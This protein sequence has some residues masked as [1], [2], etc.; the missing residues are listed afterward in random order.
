MLPELP[1]TSQAS[2]TDYY[3]DDDSQF[4]EALA[5]AV[6]PGD[7]PMNVDTRELEPP[8]LTQPRRKR[9]KSPTPELDSQGAGGQSED[10]EEE[11]EEELEPPPPAQPRKR[12][13][14]P[15]VEIEDVQGHL[16][17]VG[18]AAKDSV[19]GAATFGD[20]GQY[21]NRKR[22]KLQIQ[23]A[24]LEGGLSTEGKKQIFK[25]LAIYVSCLY[26]KLLST[27]T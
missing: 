27:L 7:V 21:M 14:S 8:P 23:N 19:Y 9:S 20:F 3:G 2:S 16:I 5:N 11:E 10:K 26:C 1:K 4:L 25:G 24:E 6:L 13:R 15:S 22:A 17:V 12:Q 18:T